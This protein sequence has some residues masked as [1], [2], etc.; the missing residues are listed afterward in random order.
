MRPGNKENQVLLYIRLITK[1]ARLC[2]VYMSKRHSV[3]A[4]FVH[5]HCI[6][7]TPTFVGDYY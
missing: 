2:V 7:M 4:L 6:G 3:L 5:V 1:A